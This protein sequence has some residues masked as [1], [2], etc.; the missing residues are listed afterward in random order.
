MITGATAGIGLA[1]A[2]ELARLGA[3]LVLVGR[4]PRRCEAAE[5][6]VRDAA[7]A[8][9]TVESICADLS[10]LAE[11][12]R[13][14]DEFHRRHDR[15]HVLINNVGAMFALRRVTAEGIESTLALN[16][17]SP[18]LL[19]NLLLDRLKA[20][21]PSR[22]INVSSAAHKD[23]R[24]FNFDDP[25]AERGYGAS[26]TSS[27]LNAL[28][29]P[30]AHPGFRRYAETKLANLLF[31]AALAKR[32]AGTGVTANALHPGF[33]ASRFTAGNGALG[34]FMRRWAGVLA[35]SPE[36]GAKTVVYLAASPDV[37]GVTGKYFVKEREASPSPAAT[38]AAAAERL[39]IMS[40]ELVG[41]APVGTP[42]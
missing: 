4:D 35:I 21:A 3:S 40:E 12:R 14:A 26:E 39:W 17:L 25:Q 16:H 1:A 42:D 11:V 22:I 27:L 37:E 6:E 28:T 24:A 2:R 29:R 20:A 19:T 8:S 13:V 30:W 41:F 33:V 7:P 10:S 38:D 15:L 31:T 32:L 36:E 34:W 9:V 18:F 5:E 23:V